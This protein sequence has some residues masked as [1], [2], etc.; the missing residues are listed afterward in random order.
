[1][2]RLHL[3]RV[4]SSSGRHHDL[5][6]PRRRTRIWKVR[7]IPILKCAP[8]SKGAAEKKHTRAPNQRLPFFKGAMGSSPA[9]LLSEAQSALSQRKKFVTEV[10]LPS[11]SS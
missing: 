11:V 4:P 5:I 1:M 9:S 6:W 7:N 10:R 3:N 2:S 8:S